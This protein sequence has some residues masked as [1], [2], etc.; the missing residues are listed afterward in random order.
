MLQKEKEI[1][2]LCLPEIQKL[3][4]A[5]GIMLVDFTVNLELDE[6]QRQMYEQAVR[7]QRMNAQG[8]A[9]ARIIGAGSKVE[10]LQMMGNAYTTIKGMELLQTIAEN[11]GAGGIASAGAGL[12]MGMAAGNTFAGIAQTVFSGGNIPQPQQPQ[13]QNFGGSSRFGVGGNP[14]PTTEQSQP[15][16]MESLQKMK[17]MLD[18]GLI[19]QTVYDQKVAEILSRL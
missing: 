6:E 17:Q 5:Y 9:Q 18:A 11:P 12:G 10:E 1:A 8:E 19:P 15:D 3:L 14:Q 2:Q 13:Q 16:P 4:D 7:L